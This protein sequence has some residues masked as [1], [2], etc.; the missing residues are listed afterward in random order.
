MIGIRNFRRTYILNSINENIFNLKDLSMFYERTAISCFEKYWKTK[1]SI[2]STSFRVS[3]EKLL[4]SQINKKS[5]KVTIEKKISMFK[6]SSWISIHSLHL[7]DFQK[8]KFS[9][10]CSGFKVFLDFVYLDCTENKR[11]VG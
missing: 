7:F 4:I 5:V 3:F 1:L 11:R 9:S 8:T 6:K 2:L 10:E